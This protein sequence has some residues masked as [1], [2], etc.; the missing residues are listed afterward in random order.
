MKT[1]LSFLLI[2]IATTCFGQTSKY[3]L[4][5]ERSVKNVDLP[6]GWVKWGKY[7]LKIDSTNV[8]SQSKSVLIDAENGK[9]F[10][11]VA[12]KLPSNFKGK[13]IKL[14]G[15]IKCENVANGYVG[16]LLRMDKDGRSVGFDNM[17]SQN[18]SGTHDWKK[19]SI[20]LNF[21]KDADYIY[22]GGLLVGPGKA[23]FDNF[24]VTIDGKSIENL[25]PFK[26]QLS[27]VEKDTEFD[28]E[29]NFTKTSLSQ[30]EQRNLF[31]LGKV[32]GFVKYYHPTVTKGEVS[33]DYEL[34]RIIS[35]V[36]QNDFDAELVNWINKLGNFETENKKEVANSK[37]KLE[38]NTKWIFD[39]TLL[40]N[41][42]SALLQKINSAKRSVN[43][44]Y[45]DLHKNVLNPKFTNEKVYANMDYSDSGI[46][47]VAVFRFWNMIEYYFPNRHLMDENWDTVL[48]DFVPKITATANEKEYTLTLLELIGKIQDTHANIWG[49]NRVLDDF[50]GVNKIPVQVKFVQNKLIIVELENNFTDNN[51]QVGTVIT[52]INGVTVEEWVTANRKYF[53]ASNAPV[54]LRDVASKITRT[55]ENSILL[56]IENEGRIS[57]VNVNTL[58]NKFTVNDETLSH[59]L[60]NTNIG[61]IYPGTL[62][63]GEINEIMTKFKNTKGLIVDLRCY[64]SEF[65]AYIMSKKL[66]SKNELFVRF[67]N[68]S[69][70]T[71]G[72]FTEGKTLS[73]GR[74]N[75][76]NYKGKVIILIN[77]QT[78]SSA[79]YTV[80]ALRKTPN[81]IV[82][83]STTA[84]ADGNISAIYL[85]GNILTY[86][87]G[88]GVLNPDK[89]ET[90]RVGIIPDIFMEPTV[91]GVREGKDELLEKAV[92]LISK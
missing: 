71:P 3:N 86:I 53:P 62:N 72:L 41:D 74:K 55:N 84:G 18:L 66:L 46:K 7:N 64:P 8:Q 67:T 23:W 51:L 10:G 80:M 17:A 5:F 47:L 75:K 49:Y 65:I 6:E 30:I 29:S 57:D 4:D 27:I 81:S 68:G 35:K 43:N 11:S 56:T 1:Y 15:Y 87:S 79:E 78:Q 39:T 36:N 83:G 24:K 90:Q 89:T 32:W 69:I 25:K 54:Q 59:K 60:I 12:Y 48:K 50:F 22:V 82:L 34:F 13:Y 38:P 91:K 31:V 21:A 40:S 26:R 9:E 33:W 63:R 88:I 19:Y 58:P 61:Y 44:Y 45:I 2:L 76:N 85:P 20:T 37:V 52:A 28:K 16:L 42:L 70:E 77:E 92:E 73:V 14:E